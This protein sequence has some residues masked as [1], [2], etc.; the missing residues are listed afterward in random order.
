[1]IALCAHFCDEKNECKAAG[2][3]VAQIDLQYQRKASSNEPLHL[4]MKQ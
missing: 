3:L 2:W 1:M 4:L